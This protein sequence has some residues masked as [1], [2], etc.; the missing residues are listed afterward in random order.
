MRSRLWRSFLDAHVDESLLDTDK[1]DKHAS[2]SLRL[3]QVFLSPSAA[4]KRSGDDAVNERY[5]EM[6]KTLSRKHDR[7]NPLH[8]LSLIPDEVGLS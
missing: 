2:H 8:A 3:P 5:V 1:Q 7:I 4:V 6:A